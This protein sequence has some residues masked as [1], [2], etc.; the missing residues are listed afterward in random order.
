VVG[1]IVDSDYFCDLTQTDGFDCFVVRQA[2]G[3]RWFY[4]RNADFRKQTG[5]TCPVKRSGAGDGI[6]RSLNAQTPDIC[7][8]LGGTSDI[9]V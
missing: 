8:E 2:G 4:G 9:R 3:R 1:Q 7:Y 6:S 5:R